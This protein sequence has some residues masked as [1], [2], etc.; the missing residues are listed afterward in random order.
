LL[1]N[2]AGC[3][4]TA[5]E[6]FAVCI[7]IAA[8][9][10]SAQ[11]GLHTWL[12]DAMEGPTPV[13]AL[14]HAATMVTAGVLLLIKCFAVFSFMP[15]LSICIAT[16]GIL[17]SVFAGSVACVQHD[18]KKIIAY[19]TCSQLGL[20]FMACGFGYPFF[21]FFHLVTHAFFKALLFLAAGSVIHAIGGSQDI[22]T[23]G[24]LA[25]YLPITNMAFLFGNLCI[26]GFPFFSG[27]YSKE[28]LVLGSTTFSLFFFVLCLLSTALTAFYSCRLY[29]CVMLRPY[30]GPFAEWSSSEDLFVELPLRPNFVCESP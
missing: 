14:I 28:L 8:M 1:V 12:P 9:A 23:M 29:W 15:F 26:V 10:K 17:T 22:R 3:H 11:I 16:I 27:F 25:R 5:L 4:F 2:I 24:G 19:S 21:A 18:I 13:S 20:M 30:A 6:V 7:V